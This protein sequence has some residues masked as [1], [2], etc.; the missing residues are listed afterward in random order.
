[1]ETWSEWIRKLVPLQN[2]GFPSTTSDTG[3]VT[4]TIDK[5]QCDVCWLRLDFDTFNI[6]GTGATT[7][8]DGG[9]CLDDLTITSTNPNTIPTICGQ[10]AGQHSESSDSFLSNLVQLHLHATLYV[11]V[12]DQCSDSATLTFNF[13]ATDATTGRS[14][15]IKVTQVECWNQNA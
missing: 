5:C 8:T 4:W 12:G 1:M 2:P 10:N 9:V 6:L 3:S 13:D 11:D 7:E 14:W 15:E